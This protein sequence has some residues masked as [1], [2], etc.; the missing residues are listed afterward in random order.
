MMENVPS[1]PAQEVAWLRL[2]GH[3]LVMNEDDP[4]TL[5]DHFQ[6]NLVNSSKSPNSVFKVFK[7]DDDKIEGYKNPA[8]TL[9]SGKDNVTSFVIYVQ[10]KNAISQ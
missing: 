5:E 2:K 9:G 8:L 10:L 6:E 1:A 3:S 4:K 7:N